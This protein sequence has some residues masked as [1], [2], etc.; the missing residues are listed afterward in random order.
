M[1]KKTML[2]QCSHVKFK[3]TM[4]KVPVQKQSH[5]TAQKQADHQDATD[6]QN[7]TMFVFFKS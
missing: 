7:Q 5:R 1:L 3:G 4:T 6:I 2:K